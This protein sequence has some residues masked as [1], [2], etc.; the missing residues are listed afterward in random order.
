MDETRSVADEP[1]AK[2]Y[3]P[4]IAHALKVP[5]EPFWRLTD[6]AVAEFAELTALDFLDRRTSYRELGHLIDR[7]AAGFQALGVGRGV[8]VGLL[9]PNCPY[10][11]ICY[12]AVLKAGG[13]IV[14]YNP[15]YV[16]REIV[17]QID[18]S[19]TEIMVT[20]DLK[21][22]Y[23]KIA[24]SMSQSRLK[25][26][27]VGRMAELLPFPRNLLFSIFKRGELA[28]V[29]EDERHVRFDRLVAND[30]RVR[31]VP[32]DPE[33]DIAVLQY[34]GG[35]TGTPKAAALTHG[36]LWANLSQIEVWFPEGER[37]KE[38]TL[39]VLPFFHVFA[40]TSVM[41]FTLHCG[42]LLILLPRFELKQVLKTIDRKR[43][44][45]FPGVPTIY[46][47]INNAP[48]LAKYDLSSIKLC[49]SGAATLP[50]E[51]KR[52]FEAHTGCKLVEGYGLSEASPVV[53]C[54]PI[55]GLNKPG[56]IGLPVPGTE[57]RIMSLDEPHRPLPTGERGELWVRGP[58]VMAEYWHQ[59]EETAHTLIDGW[60]RTGD[61]GYMDADGYFFIVDRLKEVIIAGGYKIYPR[62]VEEAIYQNPAVAEAAVVGVPDPYRGA[63]VM[64]FVVKHK[65]ASLD[66][67]GL[68][69]FLADKLSAIEMPKLIEFRDEL[70]KSAVGKIL[71]KALIEERGTAPESGKPSSPRHG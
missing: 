40:M 2:S 37:G 62:T 23:D 55:Y 65:G 19:E 47:A 5:K 15:L 71:K 9:L 52:Q 16:P 31:E 63:T 24:L 35:T 21:L 14:N 27:V 58:Q 12:F 6:E 67:E 56:S 45:L 20:L 60:L 25:R 50:A 57:V 13:T 42:G 1:W 29:P 43:P 44:T 30:G 61:V 34:T 28:Q 36:N 38:R 39:A 66:E 17:H 68:R 51:V 32:G 8:K 33:R 7:A 26:I 41:N 3:P 11:V 18:D 4:G 70:P 48:D 22:L 46:T 53:C 64:A 69:T 59:P 49:I 10:Y 54:N